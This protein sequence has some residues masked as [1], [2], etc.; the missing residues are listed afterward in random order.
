MREKRRSMARG[1]QPDITLAEA[2]ANFTDVSPE[3]ITQAYNLAKK[4]AS[5]KSDNKRLTL[6]DIGNIYVKLTQHKSKQEK[7]NIH[8]GKTKNPEKKGG[9]VKYS[10]GGGVR[11]A[12]YKI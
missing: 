12:K 3:K 4:I 2:R 11:T 8:I 9:K 5:D 6:S 1:E 7:K 10:K